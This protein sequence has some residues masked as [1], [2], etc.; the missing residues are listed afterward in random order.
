[1]KR[2]VR[3]VDQEAFDVIMGAL[4]SVENY[5][6]GPD[7]DYFLVLAS[8]LFFVADYEAGVLDLDKYINNGTRMA[9]ERGPFYL[10]STSL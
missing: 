10:L 9:T 1:M 4:T 6:L 3:N 8:S 2:V 5:F 7:S